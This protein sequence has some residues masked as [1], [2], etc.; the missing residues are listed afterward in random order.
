MKWRIEEISRDGDV[1]FEKVTAV[2]QNSPRKF[3]LACV[4]V[5]RGRTTQG[6]LVGEVEKTRTLVLL[7]VGG[8]RRAQKRNGQHISTTREAILGLGQDSHTITIFAKVRELLRAATSF[9]PYGTASGIPCVHTLQTW[10][11]PSSYSCVSGVGRGPKAFRTSQRRCGYRAATRL[12]S[13]SLPS[14][15]RAAASHVH[16]NNSWRSCQSTSALNTN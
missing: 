8:S 11:H 15:G 2:R 9:S 14:S 1:R 7:G 3:M 12:R 5:I 16:F 4:M 6:P 10:R 13:I